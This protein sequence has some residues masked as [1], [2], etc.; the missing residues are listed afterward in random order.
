M[1]S[2]LFELVQC[3]QIQKGNTLHLK[4]VHENGK[5]LLMLENVHAQPEPQNTNNLT[6][7]FGIPNEH[8]GSSR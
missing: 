4:T 2:I 6:K 7:Q 5:T 1:I 3:I 8:I